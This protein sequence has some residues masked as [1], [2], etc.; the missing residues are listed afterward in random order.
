[1]DQQQQQ[2]LNPM[3]PMQQQPIGSPQPQPPQQQQQPFHVRT[4]SAPATMQQNLTLQQQQQQQQQQAGVLQHLR[5]PSFDP[6]NGPPELS[7]AELGPLPPGWE[8]AATAEGQVY[9]MNHD[10]K[11]TQW[12]DPRKQLRQQMQVVQVMNGGGGGGSGGV[13]PPMAVVPPQQQPP[14]PPSM[15]Q[16]SVQ[17]QPQLPRPSSND[18]LG[19]LPPR[20]EQDVTPDGEIYFINHDTQTT[21]WYDPRLPTQRQQV[22]MRVPSSASQDCPTV[23]MTPAQR[24]QQEARL[25]RLEI[26][27]KRMQERRVELQGMM[28]ARMLDR[29]RAQSQESM[30]V[31]T[32]KYI[33]LTYY[34]FVALQEENLTEIRFFI[35]KIKHGFHGY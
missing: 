34:I 12:E 31:R 5:Q 26:E 3:S 9:F 27:R 6:V 7:G 17:P 22:P 23:G 32:K 19:P 11:T 28:A 2:D 21:T 18:S 8:Q 25:A 4:S 20:W 10:T 15:P 16:Q 30:T 13:R 1:M 35:S 14:P 33:Y 29:Q 24:R